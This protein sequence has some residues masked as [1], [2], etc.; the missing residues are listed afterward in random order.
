MGDVDQSKWEFDQSNGNLTNQNG[1]FNQSKLDAPPQKNEKKR[2]SHPRLPEGNLS[3]KHG[4]AL[5][6]FKMKFRFSNCHGKG[7]WT[8]LP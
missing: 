6:W 3:N 1:E 2:A 8:F 7:E 4:R 5:G